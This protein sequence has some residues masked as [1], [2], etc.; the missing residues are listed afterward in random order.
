MVGD[1]QGY[2]GEREEGKA[3]KGARAPVE[4]RWRF[5]SDHALVIGEGRGGKAKL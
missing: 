3:G 5:A 1:H 2:R 4:E